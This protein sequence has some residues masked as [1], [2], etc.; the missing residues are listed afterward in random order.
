M[1]GSRSGHLIVVSGPSGVGKSSIVSAVMDQPRSVFSTS[2]TT[3]NPRPGEMDGREYHFLDRATF[4]E[5]VERGEILEWAEYGGNR[6]GTLRREVEPKL[7]EGSHVI[8]DIENEGARQIRHSYPEA[9]LVF[10][11]PPNLEELER[12]LRGRGDT[13]EVDIERRLAVAAAQI[14]E[15]ETLYDHVVLNDDLGTAIGRVLDILSGLEHH[16][17]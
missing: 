11:R 3:R 4:D 15:A 14:L 7:A 17:A 2:A 10:I 12:R 5:L 8:L 13:T 9:V 1:S 6:Y 16:P